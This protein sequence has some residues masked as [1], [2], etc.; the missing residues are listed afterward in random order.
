MDVFEHFIKNESGVYAGRH[1]I[2][3]LWGV[4]NHSDEDQILDCFSKAC[5]DA[6]ATVLFRHCHHFGENYGTTGVVV[7]STSHCS[8]HAWPETSMV[9]IDIF[10]CGDSDPENAMPRIK[11][12]WQPE[13]VDFSL[14]RRG[15]VQPHKL[16]LDV[17]QHLHN[18]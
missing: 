16:P 5:E 1:L 14:M 2:V 17:R 11:E 18:H 10:M 6:G 8:W 7:L 4:I 15:I 9:A 3:D 13:T 12:F